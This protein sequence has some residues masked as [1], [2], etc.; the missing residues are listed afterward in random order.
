LNFWLETGLLGLVCFALLI[1]FSMKNYARKPSAIKLGASL[2][3]ISVIVH[4]MV[5]APY[6]KNDLSV[7]FWFA[8]TLIHNKD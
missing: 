4:G 8:L 1:F 2:F 7:L 6:F 5:D 3:L